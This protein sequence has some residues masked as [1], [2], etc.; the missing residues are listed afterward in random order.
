MPET[1][2]RCGTCGWW[3]EHKERPEHINCG[4]CNAMPP[5]KPAHMPC[6]KL[7][8]KRMGSACP[9]WKP[10]EEESDGQEDD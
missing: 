5:L 6:A 3:T 8:H 1:D 9:C 10:R 4:D 7:T 2:K